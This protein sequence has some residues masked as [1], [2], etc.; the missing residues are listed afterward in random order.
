[1]FDAL[2][3]A[4]ASSEP[5]AIR[6]RLGEKPP[7]P[8]AQSTPARMRCP[9]KDTTG[10]GAFSLTRPTD[11]DTLRSCLDACV[12]PWAATSITSSIERWDGPRYLRKPGIMG[13][14]SSPSP[15]PP[16]SADA[17]AGLLADVQ[18]LASAALARRRWGVVPV[19]AL[20]DD[21]PHPALACPSPHGRHRPSLPGSLQGLSGARGRSPGDGHGR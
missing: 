15:G 2:D 20:V 18:S 21:D 1:M 5:G 7:T 13:L 6:R 4:L 14:S 19:P 16:R 17:F 12:L 8:A 3:T 10:S 9:S 11:R